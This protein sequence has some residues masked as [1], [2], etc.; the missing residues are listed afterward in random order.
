[1]SVCV[2]FGCFVRRFKSERFSV[3]TQLVNAVGQFKTRQD[4]V[5]SA[6]IDACLRLSGFSQNDSSVASESTSRSIPLAQAAQVALLTILNV[7][8]T[9]LRESAAKGD[10]RYVLRTSVPR[11]QLVGALLALDATVSRPMVNALIALD[12]GVLEQFAQCEEIS[13]GVLE[14][15]VGG[16]DNTGAPTSDPERFRAERRQLLR[17]LLPV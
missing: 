17:R 10:E 13:R 15:L 8:S 5:F 6:V 14:V 7:D 16:T 12:Q 9:R 1:M 3:I 11:A 4:R 2:A